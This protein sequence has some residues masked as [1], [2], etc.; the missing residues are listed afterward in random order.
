MT[1]YN[2]FTQDEPVTYLAELRVDM[3][4]PPTGLFSDP[5][6]EGGL[7]D[8]GERCEVFLVTGDLA[9]CFGKILA[10]LASLFG[11]PDKL[12]KQKR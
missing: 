12:S 11:Q 3:I 2:K 5:L 9:E 1:D 6:A 7:V 4:L 10:W 8:V